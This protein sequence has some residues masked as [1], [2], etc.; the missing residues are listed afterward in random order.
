M[1]LMGGVLALAY[2]LLGNELSAILA[3][4]FSASAPLIIG[5][6]SKSPAQID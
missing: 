3:I 6:I 2:S 1:V 5:N 4:N